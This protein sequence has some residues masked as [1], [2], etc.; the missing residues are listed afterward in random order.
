LIDRLGR[1]P[2]HIEIG[3]QVGPARGDMR[4]YI[5]P[6]AVGQGIVASATVQRIAA[7]PA[8]DG[9]APACVVEIAK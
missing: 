7:S 1:N 4:K 6:A 9:I 5:R 2:R 8:L 3:D